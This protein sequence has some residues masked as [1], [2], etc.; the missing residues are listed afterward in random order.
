MKRAEHSETKQHTCWMTALSGTKSFCKISSN[1]AM[2]FVHRVAFDWRCG[3][4]VYNDC[5]LKNVCQIMLLS[6]VCQITIKFLNSFKRG[7]FSLKV[8]DPCTTLE[9]HKEQYRYYIR[10]NVNFNERQGVFEGRRSKTSNL[11]GS[12]EIISWESLLLY[13]EGGWRLLGQIKV[14]KVWKI[15]I[16]RLILF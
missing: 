1:S 16:T 13:K 15:K 5:W 12:V 10:K 4:G 9:Q 6:I 7:W 2:I 14:I 3:F 11:E 8:Q